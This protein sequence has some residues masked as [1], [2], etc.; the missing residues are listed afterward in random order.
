V[1]VT[2][3]ITNKS[4]IYRNT[5]RMFTTGG[6]LLLAFLGTPLAI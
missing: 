5:M 2:H 1:E 4:K 3:D 6:F